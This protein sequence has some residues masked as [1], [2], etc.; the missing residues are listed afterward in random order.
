M[1]SFLFGLIIGCIV[2]VWVKEAKSE[3]S[4]SFVTQS[5]TPLKPPPLSVAGKPRSMSLF[6]EEKYDSI[7][8][9]CM[10][11]RSW[12]EDIQLKLTYHRTHYNRL[13]DDA[14]RILCLLKESYSKLDEAYNLVFGGKTNSTTADGAKHQSPSSKDNSAFLRLMRQTDPPRKTTS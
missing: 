4:H 5:N 3:E 8:T 6:D 2:A 13:P 11:I 1:L 14:D 7:T 10:Y 12:A 9:H